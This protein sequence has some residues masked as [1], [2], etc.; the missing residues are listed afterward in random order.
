MYSLL[1]AAN[2]YCPVEETATAV[3]FLELPFWAL[4][5]Q[6]LEVR[7]IAMWK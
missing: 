5:N 6:K 1:T 7:K 2:W 3:Q 4:G